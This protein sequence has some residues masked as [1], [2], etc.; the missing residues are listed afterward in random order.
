MEGCA[1]TAV[2]RVWELED[3]EAGFVE[4][5]DVWAPVVAGGIVQDSCVVVLFSC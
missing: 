4:V 2:W 3:S 1:V 5:C